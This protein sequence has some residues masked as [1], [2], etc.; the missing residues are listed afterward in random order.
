[1]NELKK[2]LNYSVSVGESGSISVKT[3]LLVIVAFF[4]T[5]L[6]LRL[7]KKIVT[8]KLPKEDKP[9]FSTVFSYLKY[10]LFL[11]ILLVIL[12]NNGVKLTGLITSTAALLLGIGLALQT[13]F[14]DI[15]GGLL[16]LFDQSLHVNDI[17]EIEGKVGRVVKISLRTTK[18]ET[19]ENKTLIIPN[20]LY[21]SNTLYNWTQ[22]GIITRESINIGVAYGSDT[23]LVKKVLLEAASN[24]PAILSNPAPTVYFD[25]FGDSSLDFRLII[26]VNDSFQAVQPKSDLH[27]EIDRLF[28]LNNISIPFP[29]MDVHFKK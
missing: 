23:Q 22:N 21:L 28:K 16:I 8:R 11:I 26:S 17:I 1:M 4:L 27:F 13:F 25:K 15:V 24:I 10:F 14:Q 18:A 3:L 29:Q 9:K 12:G 20:H 6:I 7:V 2:I 5:T 19:I